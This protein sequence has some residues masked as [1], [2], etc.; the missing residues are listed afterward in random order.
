MAQITLQPVTKDNWAR[1]ARLVLPENQRGFV[2]PNVFSIAESKFEPHYQPRAILL[3][4]EVVGFLM[5]CKDDEDGDGQPDVYWLFRMMIAETHQG[6]GLGYEAV[7]LALAE[8]QT[9]GARRAYTM[10]K[11]ENEV[12]GKLYVRLG[13]RRVGV[14]EDGD[15]QLERDL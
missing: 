9:M 5:Y 13:F 14:L 6:K 4:T 12:A 15:I 3:D 11:P 2:A 7:R 1:C 8:M 10:H